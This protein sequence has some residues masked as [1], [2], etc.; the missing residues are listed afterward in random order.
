MSKLQLCLHC[1]WGFTSSWYTHTE[2]PPFSSLPVRPR[3][4]AIP[5]SCANDGRDSYKLNNSALFP[6]SQS[7]SRPS[8]VACAV[9]K[10][11]F[12]LVA[13]Y[14]K[15]TV[16]FYLMTNMKT[17]QLQNI[18]FSYFPTNQMTHHWRSALPVAL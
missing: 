1:H 5:K 2:I 11:F 6:S 3:T 10:I 18:F 13:A 16:S 17:L 12:P 4:A 8:G 7:D 9:H 15:D 14:S